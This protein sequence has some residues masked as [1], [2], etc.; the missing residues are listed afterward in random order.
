MKII[1]SD[2]HRLHAGQREFYRGELVP[3]FEKPE[4]ADFVHEAVKAR[5]IGPILEPKEF[6]VACIER[7]HAARYV[8][9]LEKAW[10]MWSALG[11]TRDAL[12]AVWPIRTF[13]DDIAPEYFIA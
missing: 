8:R 4:R 9:F 11:N 2:R 5:N 7:V 6:P 1:Y 3:C 12:P 10:D 13:R